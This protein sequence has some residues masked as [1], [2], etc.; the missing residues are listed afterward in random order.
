MSSKFDCYRNSVDAD[1]AHCKTKQNTD[2]HQLHTDILAKLC[3]LN[4]SE[5]E[6]IAAIKNIGNSTLQNQ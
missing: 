4:V 5:D 3:M 2:I 6:I 1:V